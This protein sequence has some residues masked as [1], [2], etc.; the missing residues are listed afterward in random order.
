MDEQREVPR[1][2]ALLRRLAE[3][4]TTTPGTVTTPAERARMRRSY[5]R[6]GVPQGSWIDRA[7]RGE[8]R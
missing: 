2:S 5:W 7:L 1:E 8:L 4:Q 3:H 6:T